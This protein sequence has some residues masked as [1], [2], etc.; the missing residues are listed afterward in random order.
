MGLA[1]K[2][3]DASGHVGSRSPTA[4]KSGPTGR[5]IEKGNGDKSA[6]VDSERD[7]GGTYPRSFHSA[8]ENTLS[9]SASFGDVSGVDE[10]ATLV[11]VLENALPVVGATGLSA[12]SSPMPPSPRTTAEGGGGNGG[13]LTMPVLAGLLRRTVEHLTAINDNG[14]G[15]STKVPGSEGA[16][17]GPPTGGAVSLAS[18]KP[19]EST[20]ESARGVRVI[21]YLCFNPGDVVLF[22]P[23]IPAA[24]SQNGTDQEDRRH[25]LAF[26][27]GCPRHYLNEQ[28][29]EIFREKNDAKFPAFIVGEVIVIDQLQAGPRGDRERNPYDL[30][31][32][33]TFHVVTI[34]SGTP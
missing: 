20:A 29:M 5:S 2:G 21:S 10:C 3:G 34:E 12:L 9:S 24:R 8:S 31:E 30:R 4:S 27:E 19:G 26:N 25:Y 14:P 11:A 16:A 23:V 32:G 1:S 28:S 7:E 18:G 6:T 22:L 13:V 17:S 15:S 33:T